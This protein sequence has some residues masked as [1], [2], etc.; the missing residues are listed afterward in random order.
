MEEKTPFVKRKILC[1]LCGKESFQYALPPNLYSVEQKEEDQHALKLRWYN[2]DFQ[3]I[4]PHYYVLF[5]C[6]ICYFTDFEENYCKPQTITNFNRL[7]QSLFQNNPTVQSILKFLNGKISY[8]NMNFISAL[9]LHL[10]AIYIYEL[11][12]T[13][14]FKDYKKLSRIYHRLGWLFREQSPSKPD[15]IDNSSIREIN[16]NLDVFNNQYHELLKKYKPL[17]DSLK[18]R[19]SD[20]EISF[21]DIKNPY[22]EP[23]KSFENNF[24]ETEKLINS[25]RY[26]S[27]NDKQFIQNNIDPSQKN[28][29]ESDLLKLAKVWNDV[30]LNER[31]SLNKAI[32]CYEQLYQKISASDSVSQQLG[33]LTLLIDLCIR[34]DN[35]QKAYDYLNSLYKYCSETRQKLFQLQRQ[36]PSASYDGQ[37]TKLG[38]TMETLS[39]KRNVIE[40]K[41]YGFYKTQFMKIIKENEEQTW[42]V[43]KEELLSHNIPEDIVEK[44]E[45]E[46]VVSDDSS[47]RQKK[48]FLGLF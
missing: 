35:F 16:I 38:D 1:P 27:Q 11:E 14:Q 5:H 15:E 44:I 30:P 19:V 42:E 33:I 10:S 3:N 46:Y 2:P 17:Q 26:I 36:N 29:D 7:K 25:I 13:D 39:E 9:F 34:I 23:L 37:I 48:K 8:E 41:R 45:E 28:T 12:T 6:S 21:D 40:E 18:R 47:S 24:K 43:I 4:K 20:L 22:L 32:T 31:D